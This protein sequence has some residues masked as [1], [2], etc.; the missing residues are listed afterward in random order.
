MVNRQLLFYAAPRKALDR[1][2]VMR[3]ARPANA[4]Y[5]I[6]K[7]KAACGSRLLITQYIF[8]NELFGHYFGKFV[9]HFHQRLRQGYS[10]DS[11]YIMYLIR[12]NN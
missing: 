2:T 7:T 9:K 6:F 8:C 5:F 3:R 11:F 1:V 4:S 12:T 10:G